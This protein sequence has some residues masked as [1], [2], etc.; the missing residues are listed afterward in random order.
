[1]GNDVLIEFLLELLKE[2]RDQRRKET[3]DNAGLIKNLVS[4]FE[5][6][7]TDLIL[8]RH[9]YRHGGGRIVCDGEDEIDGWFP[10]IPD[11]FPISFDIP[12]MFATVGLGFP[13]T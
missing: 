8:E 7:E 4:K 1:M 2:E 9:L 13:K 5:K 6:L 3:E 10:N 12:D 11:T